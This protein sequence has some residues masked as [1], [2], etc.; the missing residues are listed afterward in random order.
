MSNTDIDKAGYGPLEGQEY[1]V[2][3][4]ATLGTTASE[5]TAQTR[6]ALAVA[7]YR[8]AAFWRVKIYNPSAGATLAWATSSPT[9]TV[10]AAAITADMV[11]TTAGSHIAP[12]QSEYFVIQGS[13]QAAFLRKLWI[14]ASAA[15]TSASITLSPIV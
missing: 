1:V 2:T 4:N 6:A 7:T 5:V 9:D 3:Y 15:G 14:V 10:F 8:D 11:P 13:K 12:G